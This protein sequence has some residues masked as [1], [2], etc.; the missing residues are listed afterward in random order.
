MQQRIES[1]GPKIEN[2]RPHAGSQQ[3]NDSTFAYQDPSESRT[4]RTQTVHLQAQPTGTAADSMFR[5]A[6]THIVIGHD[7]VA[8]LQHQHNGS[9]DDEEFDDRTE[10]RTMETRM[11]PADVAAKRVLY[12][13]DDRD[14]SPGQ[15]Y[16]EEELYRLHQRQGGSQSGRSHHT[17]LVSRDPGAIDD[18]EGPPPS[19]MPTIPDTNGGGFTER[20]GSHSPPLPALPEHE[21]EEEVEPHGGVI[22]TPQGPWRTH[23]YDAETIQPQLAPWQLIHTRL[24]G[25][26]VIWPQSELDAAL[27]STTRG[28]Q[29][30]EIALN[31]WTT[32]TYKRYVRARLTDNPAG[33]VDRLFVPPNMADAISNAVY[34]G[35]HGNAAGMLKE[36][37]TSFGLPG[38]PRLLVVLARH[39]LENDHWVVHRYVLCRL[40]R[41]PAY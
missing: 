21:E 23:D 26:A 3:F 30:D 33:I 15:Q 29:I 17:W 16:L 4:P 7:G 28:Q 31:I 14:D 39:R 9:G 36:M 19:G 41:L 1:L 32:Q 27:N 34:N 11:P 40:C 10:T 24:L 2:L 18:D 35:Q 25:W 22:T 38:M 37:W 5:G 6:Q 20:E 12:G 8:R 13:A